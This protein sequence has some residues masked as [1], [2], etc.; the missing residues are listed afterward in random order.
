MEGHPQL[1][2][3]ESIIMEGL[4]ISQDWDLPPME[5]PNYKSIEDCKERVLDTLKEELELG[6][7]RQVQYK[8]LIVNA[9]GA[10]LK[11]GTTEVRRITDL[12]LDQRASQSTNVY[13][14]SNFVSKR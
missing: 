10:V 3:I 4:S 14:G 8:P 1:P 2:E 6:R 13:H 9:I 5:T 7:I 11:A 12:S